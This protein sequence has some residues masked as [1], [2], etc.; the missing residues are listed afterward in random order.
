VTRSAIFLDPDGVLYFKT[1]DL[2]TLDDVSLLPGAAEAIKKLNKLNIF[3]CSISDRAESAKGYYSLDRVENFHKYLGNLLHSQAEA[4]LDAFYYCPYLSPSHGGVNPELTRWSTWPKPNTGMLVAAA[5]EYDLDLSTSFVIGSKTADI[6]LA[7]N[8]GAKSIL[9]KKENGK[10]SPIIK[11]KNRNAP[12]FVAP[13]LI[14][15]VNY[16]QRVFNG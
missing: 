1:K 16:I 2:R 9:I 15:A 12:D 6:C 7:H 11:P 4:T 5:W 8:V 13:D 10:G 3:C 14:E